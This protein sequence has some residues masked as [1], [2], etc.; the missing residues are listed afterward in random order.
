[1]AFAFVQ[2]T[3]NGIATTA[4]LTLVWPTPTTTNNLVVFHLKVASTISITGLTDSA[5]NLYVT[6]SP[7]SFP[8]VAPNTRVYQCYG[9]Q[10][11]PATNIKVTVNASTNLFTLADE[12]S[13]GEITNNTIFD[14]FSQGSGSGTA[15]SASLLVPSATGKLIV[16]TC[17]IFNIA[18]ITAGNGYTITGTGTRIRGQ[19]KLSGSTSETGSYGIST[20]QAYGTILRA[21]N[22]YTTPPPTSS[23]LIM[24]WNFDD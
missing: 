23:P 24:M 21:Y 9:I 19:Y 7:R 18:T 5:G 20:P 17:G 11:S 22:L 8:T 1:M 10:T 4:S 12:F 3:P 13:G 2:S 6:G 15:G 14:S 16:G